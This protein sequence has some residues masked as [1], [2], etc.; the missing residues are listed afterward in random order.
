[1]RSLCLGCCS[2]YTGG[3]AS[4]GIS[5]IESDIKVICI[6]FIPESAR[7]LLTKGRDEEARIVLQK[8]A[9]ENEVDLPDEMLDK[10][11]GD[12]KQQDVEDKETAA[13]KKAE[14]SILDLMK[15]PNLRR[16]T[17]IILFLW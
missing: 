1:M 8:A 2:F 7:W 14:S 11:L 12:M 6:R 5:S 15:H 16:K 9:K 17:F 13:V 10:F 3:K 4:Y